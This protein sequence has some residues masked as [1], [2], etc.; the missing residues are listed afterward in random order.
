[1][2]KERR[3]SNENWPTWLDQAW[4]LEHGEVGCVQCIDFPNSDGTDKLEIVTL[5]GV[6]LV[7]WGDYIIRGVK[8]ELYPCK[9]DIFEATY[10]PAGAP[11]SFQDRVRLEK[12]E[13]DEKVEKLEAFVI[14]P[15]FDF[16]PKAEKD[17]LIYQ[18]GAMRRYSKVLGERIAAF[19]PEVA[20]Q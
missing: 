20:A 14:G 8:G 19:E 10:E 12:E 3:C 1:M 4:N 7:E 13:L 17:R 15:R 9:P 2:T 16:L 18:C 11:E 6:M 5:E